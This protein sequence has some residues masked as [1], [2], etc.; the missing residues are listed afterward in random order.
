[1]EFNT[2]LVATDGSACARG[3][4]AHG[5]AVARAFDARVHA[6]SAVDPSRLGGHSVGD[7]TDLVERRLEVARASARDALE[8]VVD[9]ADAAG[10]DAD[11]AVVEARPG[12]ALRAQA[13]ETGADL[14]AM[15]THGRTG[16]DHYLVGSVA[17]RTVRTSP[18]PTLVVHGERETL[19]EYGTVVV[20]TDGSVHAER[21]AG[22]A[23]ALAD[24][25][26]ATVHALHV[27]DGADGD[28]TAAVRERAADAGVPAESVVRDGVPSRAI[29]DYAD[30][31]G[32]DLVA[33]GTH[34]RTGLDRRLVG[35][36]AE[37]TVRTATR[38]VLTAHAAS[39]SDGD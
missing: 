35:S 10:V 23:V 13:R 33:M 39:A 2:V 36:V 20:P 26:G 16:L 32:A 30:E 38:P 22:L 28:P 27:A 18:V 9:V 12:E 31:V 21:A 14:V 7:V 19:P 24:A 11:T 8:H 37:R 29:V 5:V 15:G 6:V 34:G 25:F 17:E 1:M 3:A 4:V